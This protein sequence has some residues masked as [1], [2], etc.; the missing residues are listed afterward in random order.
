MKRIVFSVIFFILIL[1]F[2]SSANA[3]D[4]IIDLGDGV[5]LEMVKISAG[6]SGSGEVNSAENESAVNTVKVTADFYIGKYEV[7]QGQW[8]KI[9]G[10]NPS[11]FSHGPNYPVENVSWNEV[12][13][14]FI[15]KINELKPS[16]LNGFRLPT[17]AEWEYACRAGSQAKFFFGNDPDNKLIGDYVWYCGNS[18]L[19]IHQVGKKK[20]N[21][22]GLYDMLGN[23]SEWCRDNRDE[24]AQNSSATFG[25]SNRVSRGGT[26]ESSVKNCRSDS[27]IISSDSD[28]FS[29]V[30]FRLAFSK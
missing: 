24:A 16:G 8:T 14:G 7:T 21:S 11:N 13:E 18:S 9:M 27:R 25:T 22:Y 30:G 26:C 3:S 5:K 12:T 2:S 19:S 17:E 15:E 1:I 29:N 20:P 4:L 23:V 28:R 10:S 6:G